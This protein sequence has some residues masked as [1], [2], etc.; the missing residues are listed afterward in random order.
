MK[1]ITIRDLRQRWPEAEAA[2][3]VEDEIIITRDSKPVAKLVRVLQ[4]ET[5]RSRWNLEEHRRWIKKVFGGKVFPSSDERL[6][7]A[8]ADRKLA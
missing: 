7:A 1:T 5:K 4:P 8:R 2:L 6:D 3:E